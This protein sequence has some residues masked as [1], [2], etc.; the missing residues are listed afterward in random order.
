MKSKNLHVLQRPT[1]GW[2]Y[3]PRVAPALLSSGAVTLARVP[4]A[5]LTAWLA[6]ARS[7]VGCSY[8]F[9][10][11]P[12]DNHERLYDF[13]CTT[14]NVFPVVDAVAAGVYGIVAGG[15]ISDRTETTPNIVGVVAV[16]AA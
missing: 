3:F 4:R 10:T 7:P 6:L 11:A 9:A 12:P 13:D 5:A 2:G 8:L 14:G 15:M 1:W 16:A